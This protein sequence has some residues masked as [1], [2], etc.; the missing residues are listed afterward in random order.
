M[1]LVCGY[2]VSGCGVELKMF[3]RF[4]NLLGIKPGGRM[5]YAF[6]M[7]DKR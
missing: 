1:T 3:E 6:F 5:Q 2:S 7:V 4:I